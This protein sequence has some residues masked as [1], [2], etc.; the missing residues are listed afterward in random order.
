MS[1]VS[2]GGSHKRDR[3]EISRCKKEKLDYKISN[4]YICLETIFVD[5][6]KLVLPGCQKNVKQFNL[7]VGTI[8]T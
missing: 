4:S 2:L 6:Q 8:S 5:K 7:Y 1:V 3:D